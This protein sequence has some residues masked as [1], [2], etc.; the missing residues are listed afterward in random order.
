[1][2]YN[3]GTMII[4]TRWDNLSV[5]Q[6]PVSYP[7]VFLLCSFNILQHRLCPPLRYCSLENVILANW[8]PSQSD[9]LEDWPREL[10]AP[11]GAWEVAYRLD[12]LNMIL[13]SFLFFWRGSIHFCRMM[14]CSLPVQRAGNE[15]FVCTDF[16]GFVHFNLNSKLHI[17]L[18]SFS[19]H[20]GS[21]QL[22]GNHALAI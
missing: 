14:H 17:K 3:C 21:L 18:H 2:C 7:K 9:Q 13:I 8:P 10:L 16:H 20:S 4:W 15:G 19:E 1:M 22:K 12:T 6:L 11:L 5:N